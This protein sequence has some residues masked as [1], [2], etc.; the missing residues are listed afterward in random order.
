MPAKSSAYYQ[1]RFRERMKAQGFV[2]REVWIPPDR[3]HVLK[4]CEEALRK[5]RR[6]AI[7]VNERT[8]TMDENGD[9]WTTERLLGALNASDPAKEGDLSVE[10]IEGTD[11]GLLITMHEYGDLPLFAS[12]AGSQIVIDTL[13]WPVDAVENS[14]A[15]NMLLLRSHKLLPLSAFGI[16]R[17]AQGVDHYEIFG[18]LSAGSTLN[19]ILAE[20]ET[21]AD[22]TLQVVEAYAQHLNDTG[23]AA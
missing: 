15:F 18:A 10:L 5:G 17:D 13:L 22:N 8:T 11:P 7:P 20:I 3:A 21:L 23:T 4:I 6:P 14:A 12:V 2:K 1:A 9:I 19:S 16:V